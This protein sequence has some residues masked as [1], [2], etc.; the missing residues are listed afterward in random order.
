MFATH[1][2][3]RALSLPTLEAPRPTRS[4][5]A[6]VMISLAEHVEVTGFG[7][8]GLSLARP[9][10]GKYLAVVTIFMLATVLHTLP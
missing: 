3:S 10:R 8:G 6:S 2:K 4:G 5:R 7:E 9:N 1:V